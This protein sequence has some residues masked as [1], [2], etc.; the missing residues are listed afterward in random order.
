MSILLVSILPLV[1]L[2]CWLLL[3]LILWWGR[4]KHM[5]RLAVAL[6]AKLPL[7][8]Q[9]GL[10]FLVG[11]QQQEPATHWLARQLVYLALTLL[12]ISLPPLHWI[13]LTMLLFAGVALLRLRSAVR[14][15]YRE[16]LTDL[17]PLLDVIAML[18]KSGSSLSS[19]WFHLAASAQPG[20]LAREARRVQQALVHGESQLDALQAFAQRLPL[21]EVEQFVQV[22]QH[23]LATGGNLAETLMFQAQ[24]RREERLIRLEKQAQEAPVKLLLPL[25][26]C[27]FPVS[28]LILLGPIFLRFSTS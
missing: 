22:C 28:F 27:F 24:Q 11:Q 16:A 1:G 26:A 21:R 23:S 2:S 6:M 3:Q 14:E 17:P 5:R 15:L 13:G 20:V 9:A 25:V 7:Q 4:S 12:F 19:A 18:L 10:D 8:L